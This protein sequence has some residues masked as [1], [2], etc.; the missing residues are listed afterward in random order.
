[1]DDENYQICIPWNVKDILSLDDSLTVEQCIEA[2][3]YVEENFDANIG[4]N[5]NVLQN[6]IDK[7]KVYS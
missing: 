3:N 4:I 5:W 2:L 1:M 7:I 6:A